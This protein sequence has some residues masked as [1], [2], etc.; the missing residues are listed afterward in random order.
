MGHRFLGGRTWAEVTREERFFCARL[1]ELIRDGGPELFV[2]LV[3]RDCGTSLPVNAGWEPAFEACFYRDL[4]NHRACHGTPFSLKRTFDLCLLSDE[5]ILIVEAKAQ[6]AF[7]PDQL[8]SFSKDRQQ[9]S[10][11]TGVKQ[12]V[13]VGL[14]SSQYSPPVSV[15]RVFDGP[16]LTWQAL[17]AFYGNDPIL[18][19]AEALFNPNQPQ[20]WGKHNNGG[21]MSG[22][23][24]LAEFARGE[25]FWVGRDKG[26]TGRALSNDIASGKWRTQ[27]YETNRTSSIP[28]SHNWF[29]L[30]EFVNRVRASGG[31]V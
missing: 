16:L 6:Q 21:Y 4:W 24:L 9:M 7:Q 23:D 22:Q 13:L 29:K 1:Y 26:I 2:Q 11:E 18:T 3:N 19:R 12:V 10:K 15:R 20:T 8:E 27:R 31:Q 5:A 14:A 17:A 28:P 25:E 30:S